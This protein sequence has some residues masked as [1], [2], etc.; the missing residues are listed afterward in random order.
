MSLNAIIGHSEACLCCLSDISPRDKPWDVHKRQSRRVAQLY[1]KTMLERYAERMDDCARWLE[2][3]FESSKTLEE[4]VIKLVN[5]QFCRVRHCPVCQWRR[6]LM[7]LARF[8]EALPEIFKAYP[9]HRFI[10]LTL[11]VRN[12]DLAQL[13]STLDWMNKS[14]EK[15]TKRKQFP[16][17]GFLKATEVTRSANGQ[18]HPHFHCLLM[19]PPGYFGRKYL[20]QKDWTA[21]W[22]SCLKVE[23]TPITHIRVVKPKSQTDDP[24]EGLMQAIRE[25]LKYSVKPEDL[26]NSS[27]DWLEELTVQLHKTRAVSV[28]GIL[29]QYLSEDEPEDLING[30]KEKSNIKPDTDIAFGWREKQERYVS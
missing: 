16:A 14:W 11:T 15:L 12:C 2:F 20:T 21:L 3:V 26:V 18:A 27:P 30:G 1:R 19:V 24:T 6:S 25:T 13:R 23:Y 29:R 4:L 8:Y 28:G 22:Q 7:W 17:V 10:F 5:T 9:T